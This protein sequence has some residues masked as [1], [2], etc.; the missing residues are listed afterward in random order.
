VKP[1]VATLWVLAMVLAPL[2]TALWLGFAAA[3]VA[4]AGCF[5]ITFYVL[6][7]SA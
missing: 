6:K 3:V 5:M 2:G 7:E 4:L 1:I